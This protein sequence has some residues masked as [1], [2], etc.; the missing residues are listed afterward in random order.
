MFT[1]PKAFRIMALFMEVV[2]NN[3]RKDGYVSEEA[4]PE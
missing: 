1:G 4:R 2:V 3:S